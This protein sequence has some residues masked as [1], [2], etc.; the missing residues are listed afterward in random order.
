VKES[1]VQVLIFARITPFMLN[2]ANSSNSDV[3]HMFLSF[4]VLI[5]TLYICRDGFL[6]T[7]NGGRQEKKK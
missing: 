2:L 7:F 4:A 3:L 6:A 5:L 1:L